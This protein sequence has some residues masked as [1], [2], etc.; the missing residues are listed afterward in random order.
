MSTHDP[1]VV[2]VDHLDY[3]LGNFVV[4]GVLLVV[5]ALLDTVS[6]VIHVTDNLT[7]VSR[8]VVRTGEQHFTMAR[9]MGYY[10]RPNYLSLPGL[11]RMHYID[12]GDPKAEH[13]LLMVHGE[14]FWSFC[15]VKVIPWF[16]SR[17]FRVIAP[18]L[19]GIN[20]LDCFKTYKQL[21][22]IHRIWQI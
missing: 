18:D 20:I 11:P 12:V 17:G 4:G 9:R 1:T 16:T 22:L 3:S 6:R 14:P 15:W 19:I 7:Y 10:Y 2:M 5:A 13:V 8:E 21:L